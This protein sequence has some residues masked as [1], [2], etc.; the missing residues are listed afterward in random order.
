MKKKDEIKNEKAKRKELINENLNDKN[1]FVEAGAGAGKTTII[2]ERILNQIKAGFDIE[3]IVVITFTNKAANEIRDRIINRIEEES[4]KEE[5]DK[6]KQNL[7]RA[8]ENIGKMQVSTI[9]S[10]CMKILKEQAFASKLHLDV[11]LVQDEKEKE[12][13]EHFFNDWYDKDFDEKFDK[14]KMN[15]KFK[16]F[17]IYN[18]HNYLFDNF[19]DMTNQLNDE[20]FVI[21]KKEISEDKYK[22]A[23]DKFN[24]NKDLKEVTNKNDD[25]IKK[26]KQVDYLLKKKEE[27]KKI[28]K[29][30]TVNEQKKLAKYKLDIANNKKRIEKIFEK[31]KV[32]DIQELENKINVE[33]NELVISAYIGTLTVNILQDVVRQ[34]RETNRNIYITN[35]DLLR[36]T[37]KLFVD[38][39]EIKKIYENKYSCVYVDEFQDTNQVQIE[40]LTKM[41]NDDKGNLRKGSIFVVGDPKQSIYRFQGSDLQAYNKFKEKFDEDERVVLN[42]NYRSNKK[43]LDFVNSNNKKIFDDSDKKTEGIYQINYQNMEKPEDSVDIDSNLL[44]DEKNLCGVYTLSTDDTEYKKRNDARKVCELIKKLVNSDYKIIT[45]DEEKREYI[46]RTI[47]FKDILVIS[48]KKSGMSDYINEFNRENIPTQ[49]TLEMENSNIDQF[50]RFLYCYLYIVNPYYDKAKY[51]FIDTYYYNLIRDLKNNEEANK[52]LEYMR[53]K[54]NSMDNFAKAYYLINNYN[55]VFNKDEL[56]L[57]EIKNL[58]IKLQQM[59]ETVI[60]N[61]DS[62]DLVQGFYDYIATNIERDI[63][64]NENEDV[65]RF[66]NLH[67][68]KGLQGNI[69]ICVCRDEERKV[70]YSTYHEFDSKNKVQY[71]FTASRGNFYFMKSFPSYANDKEILKKAEIEEMSEYDRL[72][73]VECTRAKDVLIFM[74]QFPK[75][76][77]KDGFV[78]YNFAENV[79]VLDYIFA[80]K[81]ASAKASENIY[82]TEEKNES[83]DENAGESQKSN[84]NKTSEKSIKKWKSQKASK[85]ENNKVSEICTASPSDFEKGKE[86]TPNNDDIKD[87]DNKN[88]DNKDKSKDLIYGKTYGTIMHRGF[89]ILVNENFDKSKIQFAIK[90]AITEN[91]EDL[92]YEYRE[93]IKD[94]CNKIENQLDTIYSNF[95]NNK[96]IKDILKSG[97]KYTEY[98]FNLMVDKEKNKE[99]FDNLELHFKNDKGDL[100]KKYEQI[101]PKDSKKMYIT[102]Q[103][104]LIVEKGD[105][106]FI[107]DY[108][109]DKEGAGI[110]KAYEGQLE[111]YKQVMKILFNKKTIYKYLYNNNELIELK[112]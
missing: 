90:K 8:R 62:Q 94:V 42:W 83:A 111:L 79:K 13:K 81:S 34:Y 75:V 65:V 87:T 50:Y 1:Y 17:D 25:N 74:P 6:H 18:L 12:E 106:L 48:P 96:N 19:C 11:Q 7:Q 5:D 80:E 51:A 54:T 72:A 105:E 38:H 61:N 77:D 43:I 97:K 84:D 64:L 98:H 2:T 109:S 58:Q 102:G 30:I 99:L 37:R 95:I 21:D 70:R 32:K 53:E 52:V 46:A 33:N 67:K 86:R 29:K 110:E 66:M 103:A 26:Q 47:H 104:D 24:E 73:Y 89:E 20:D 41:L 108:K 14:K 71:Y 92:K 9:H 59:F 49:F 93:K 35:N 57:V 36:K 16:G 78:N 23:F 60:S 101:V 31:Y 45:W 28:N 88:Y 56:S 44:D 4:K 107:I 69:V 3:K 10:F 27:N 22:V 91:I 15:D 68:V 82:S 100:L 63:T 40:F 39:P 76:K 85:I 112:D 55:L